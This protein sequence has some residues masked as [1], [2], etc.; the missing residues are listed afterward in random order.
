MYLLAVVS[1]R[2]RLAGRKTLE[3]SELADD[4]LLVL[5]REFGSRAWFDAACQI[6]HIKPRVILESAAPHTLLALVRTGNDVAILPSNVQIPSAS[7]RALPLVHRR[8]PIGQ[9]AVVAWDPQ[10]F[11]SKYAKQF[12]DELVVFC[13]HNYP[14]R[15]LVKH[16]PPLPKPK[17]STD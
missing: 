1:P 16:A 2:H 11:L 7:V 5:R 12:V 6:A 9:W 14:G 13:R 15:E 10:R 8:A 3:L 4:R 17:E